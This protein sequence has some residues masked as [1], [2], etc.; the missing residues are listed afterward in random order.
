MG[1]VQKKLAV[2]MATLTSG[3]S[4]WREAT[5]KSASLTPSSVMPTKTEERYDLEATGFGSCTGGS[6]SFLLSQTH[7]GPETVSRG[8]GIHPQVPWLAK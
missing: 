1:A 4:V 2:G 8:A 5:K 3:R 6:K 7:G